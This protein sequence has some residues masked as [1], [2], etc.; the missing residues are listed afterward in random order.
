MYLNFMFIKNK[1]VGS[2]FQVEFLSVFVN[3]YLLTIEEQVYFISMLINDVQ[4]FRIRG[5]FFFIKL[6]KMVDSIEQV[7]YKYIFFFIL[8]I[9]FWFNFVW[10]F[11]YEVMKFYML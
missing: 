2:V 5:F 11:F 3:V 8:D 7:N 4:Y 10:G 1:F 6:N 9:F